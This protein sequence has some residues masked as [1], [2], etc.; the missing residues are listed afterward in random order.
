MKEWVA[1]QLQQLTPPDMN[2][3][4]DILIRASERYFPRAPKPSAPPLN[5]MHRATQ[6]MW[7]RLSALDEDLRSHSLT[8]ADHEVLVNDL[9][10]W[11]KQAVLLAKKQR[12]A[13]F[14]K[15]V[16]HAANTGDSYLSHKTLKTLRPWQPQPKTQLVNQDGYLMAAEEELQLMTDH[17]K[18][19]F[20]RH[21]RLDVLVNTLPH[22]QA[23]ALA[24]HIGSIRPHKA[25]PEGS[26]SAAAWKLCSASTGDVLQQY[27]QAQSLKAEHCSVDSSVTLSAP[28][29]DTDLCFIPKPN[30]P[31][32]KPTNLRPLGIMRP[33]GKGLAGAC[34]DLLA[35][36]T[37]SYL[38]PVPQFAYQPRRGLSDAL[39]RVSQH[40]REVRHACAQARLSRHSQHAGH[41]KPELVGGIC[42]ALDLSQAFDM[43]RRQDLMDTLQEANV[44]I[45]VQ[46]LV[47][48]LH[49]DSRYKVRSQQRTSEVESTTGIKQGCKLAPTLF[50]MLTGKLLK[51]L[52][53][54]VGKDRMQQSL[55]GYADDMTIHHPINNW[56]DL[57]KAHQ[58]IAEL[59]RIVRKYGFKVNPEKCHLMVKLIGTASSRAYKLFSRVH[60]DAQGNKHRL[61]RLG[62]TKAQ[63]SFPQSH[64][65]KYLGA[66]V[67]YGNQEK[68]SLAHRLHE[69]N[70]KLQQVRR[71][72][73]N[74]RHSGPKSRLKI[75]FST[76]WATV[77]AGLVDI[78]LTADTAKQL[79]GWFARKIRA[80]L[81][82]PVHL[83]GTSTERLFEE[84]SLKDPVQILRDRQ[85]NRVTSLQGRIWQAGQ[86]QSALQKEATESLTHKDMSSSDSDVS[87]TAQALQ[88]AE[89]VLHEYDALLTASKATA[90]EPTHKCRLCAFSS[91]S[92]QGLKIH[93]VKK[94]REQLDRYVPK[95]FLPE[96][97]K[98]GL[99]TCAA[100]SKDFA[101][102]KGLKDHL[103]SGACPNPDALRDLDARTLELQTQ[104]GTTEVMHAWSKAYLESTKDTHTVTQLAR[105]HD[106][107]HFV[108]HCV[109][110]GFWTPDHTKVKSHIHQEHRKA[111]DA[112]HT[113]TAVQCRKLG[114]EIFKG[115]SC[116][117]CRKPVTDRRKHP[118]QCGVLFQ[119]IMGDSFLQQHRTTT[120]PIQAFFT[121]AA[122]RPKPEQKQHLLQ[123][124]T[125]STP[126]RPTGQFQTPLSFSSN[127]PDSSQPVSDSSFSPAHPFPSSSSPL[128]SSPP[129][130]L[131]VLSRLQLKNT[132][133][134]CY[135]NATILSLLSTSIIDP[136]L[137]SLQALHTLLIGPEGT[138]GPSA[139][140]VVNSFQLRNL[141]P[142]WRFDGTQQ[143]SAEFLQCLLTAASDIPLT[144]RWATVN[145]ASGRL[146]DEGGPI[147]MLLQHS[148]SSTLQSLI[149]AWSVTPPDSA[150]MGQQTHAI[151]AVARF[152]GAGKNHHP[153]T[154][155]NGDLT[156]PVLQGGAISRE[157][158]FV[159]SCIFHIGPSPHS[160]HYRTIWRSSP[161]SP[162]QSTDDQRSSQ[163]AT[164]SDQRQVRHGSYL[165]FLT[166]RAEEPAS[167]TL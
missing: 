127:R 116:P 98:N 27:C 81:N 67:S 151:L 121:K 154:A 57:L 108:Q 63:E 8:Q 64:S 77:S 53:T 59:L 2:E 100:R 139:L 75:W 80:V 110:C 137:R 45:A 9:A 40:T 36:Y 68:L 149:D 147:V 44:P 152:T 162:W 113:A 96:H 7:S 58:M 101:L 126:N 105:Q 124:T 17:A 55:T 119:I 159:Q 82:R 153:V 76:V 107:R 128:P 25:V 61:W 118:E 50:S 140:N 158:A 123:R 38:K 146:A 95:S 39:S 166:F 24:K 129:A 49:T 15:E 87:L 130:A 143:D 86:S 19:V 112:L 164:E 31:P 93:E 32:N 37:S 66:Y 134:Y 20:Q 52:S 138:A 115:S 109:L 83:T 148:T 72:V 33:D 85:A 88:Y 6:R 10:T 160:G 94:H 3:V 65:F 78:G 84:F 89:M 142:R 26:A 136:N 29:K 131:S 30:K 46:N 97:S 71:Y 99:P 150:L 156:I 102:W 117:Y 132:S 47:A 155:I 22:L 42:F 91:N 48:S 70:A 165:F 12:V 73:H 23:P 135:V 79:R 34:R 122:S 16:D 21:D 69:G 11:H 62:S 106:S 120:G 28:L 60:K 41:A 54:V 103:L 13:D 1:D 51:E 114:T 14:T 104:Q 125:L 144:R 74:R 18:A 90:E 5:A 4:N 92:E 43:V 111:W 167:A 163:R 35:P 141:L 157:Q 161:T 145:P 56:E 133:N